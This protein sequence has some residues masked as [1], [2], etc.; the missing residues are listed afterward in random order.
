MMLSD[1]K[2]SMCTVMGNSTKT[3]TN[4]EIIRKNSISQDTSVISEYSASVTD[5]V[6]IF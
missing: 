2:L 1:T 3:T 5:S 6:T 4:N